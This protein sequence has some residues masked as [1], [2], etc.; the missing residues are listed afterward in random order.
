MR[1][2]RC[3]RPLEPE[4]VDVTKEELMAY[5]KAYPRPLERDVNGVYEPPCITYNDFTLG[6]WPASI[7]AS[8]MAAYDENTPACNFRVL[9]NKHEVL[10]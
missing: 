2:P 4:M 8:Y 7:V 9:E 1:T 5:V 3:T 6:D 10:R